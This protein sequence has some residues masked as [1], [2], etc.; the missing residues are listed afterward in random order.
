M[1]ATP[2][3]WLTSRQAYFA[4]FEFLRRHFERGPTDEIGGIV[5][6]LSLLEDGTAADPAMWLD[7]EEATAAVLAAERMSGGYREFDL[8]LADAPPDRHCP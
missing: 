1:A 3:I 2:E 7:W 4:M 5:D 6:G 8:R